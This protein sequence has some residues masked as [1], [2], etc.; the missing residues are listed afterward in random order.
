MAGLR[1]IE[2]DILQSAR[3]LISTYQ[4]YE[5]NFNDEKYAEIN[6]YFIQPLIYRIN[7]LMKTFEEIGIIVN[8]FIK[9]DIIHDC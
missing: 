8:G 7:T 4:N 3:M 9:K 2:I 1:K 5:E 6:E